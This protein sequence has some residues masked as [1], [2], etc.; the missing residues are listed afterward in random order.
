MIENGKIIA[1]IEFIYD[2]Y[3][4]NNTNNRIYILSFLT[5]DIINLELLFDKLL[6][7]INSIFIKN[8]FQ[9]IDKISI[10]LNNTDHNNKV[11]NFIKKYFNYELTLYNEIK[12]FIKVFSFFL[13]K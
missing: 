3:Y 8:I 13:K 10:E 11:N 7:N 4:F 1:N 9:N 12:K 2:F 5:S 6:K